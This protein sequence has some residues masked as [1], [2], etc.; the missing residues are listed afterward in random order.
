MGMFD[1]IGI[2]GT[3]LTVHR[4]WLDAISDNIANVNT[5]KPM[6][7]AAFQARY[8]EVQEGEESPAS[9]SRGP[10]SAV[11]PVESPT[12]RPTPRRTRTATS[13]CPTSTS[14]RRW[15]T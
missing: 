5:V 14:A 8:V 2:A 3:G 11:P 1:A 10:P 9:T 15:P 7:G 13:A 4:K 6:S 12:T